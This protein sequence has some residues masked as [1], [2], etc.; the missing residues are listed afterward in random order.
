MPIKWNDKKFRKVV[1]DE[2]MRRLVK[3]GFMVEREAKHLAPVDTGR[4]RASISTNWTDS[5]KETG[6]VGKAAGA[7]ILKGKKGVPVDGIGRPSEK[8]TVVVGTRVQYA[9]K[10]EFGSSFQRAQ[11]FLRPALRGVIAFVNRI[12]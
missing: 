6:K 7:K 11:P 8:F 1:E 9:P 2:A 10:L 3:V 12:F 4:L 5:G